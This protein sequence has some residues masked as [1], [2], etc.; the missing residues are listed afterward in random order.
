MEATKPP[1]FLRLLYV[2]LQAARKH[3]AAGKGLIVAGSGIEWASD[4]A[5]QFRTNRVQ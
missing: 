5:L 2:T 1:E 4:A 3:L